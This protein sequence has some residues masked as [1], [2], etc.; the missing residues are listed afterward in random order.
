MD[1]VD[2]IKQLTDIASEDAE[3]KSR[4]DEARL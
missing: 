3:F 4:L 2:K 1:V